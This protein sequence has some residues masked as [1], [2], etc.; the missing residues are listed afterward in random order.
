MVGGIDFVLVPFWS[1][2]IP[3]ILSSGSLGFLVLDDK[4]QTP[5]ISFFPNVFITG[6]EERVCIED[7]GGPELGFS[8]SGSSGLEGGVKNTS[9]LKEGL[10]SASLE[11]GQ[12]GN[13]GKGNRKESS[14]K[15]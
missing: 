8:L 14:R 3:K 11:G 12:G 10:G 13:Q 4:V 6:V 2:E 5:P 1:E 9:K 7:E 15:K